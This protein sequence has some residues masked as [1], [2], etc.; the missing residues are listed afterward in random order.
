MSLQVGNRRGEGLTLNNLGSVTQARGQL[1]EAQDY[2]EQSL[3]IALETQ[4]AE[5]ESVAHG[6]LAE[7]GALQGVD[8]ASEN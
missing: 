3:A 6:N 5:L 8:E 7:T 2:Y 4:Y 1:A